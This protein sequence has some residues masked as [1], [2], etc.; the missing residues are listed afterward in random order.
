MASISFASSWAVWTSR[1]PNATSAPACAKARAQSCPMPRA[2]PV[3]NAICPCK[4]KRG[5]VWF[6]LRLSFYSSSCHASHYVTLENKRNQDRWNR[7]KNPSRHHPIDIHYIAADKFCDRDGDGLGSQ[8]AGED[9]GKEKFIPGQQ[10]HEHRCRNQSRHGD[11][12]DHAEQ[13]TQARTAIQASRIF[14]L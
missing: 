7:R 4:S 14:Q 5:K 6:I 9:Q 3:T 12:H 1:N 8:R 2:A 13:N 10:E 11:R